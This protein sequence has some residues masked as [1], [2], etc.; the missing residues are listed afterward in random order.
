MARTATDAPVLARAETHQRAHHG[1]W[2]G[3]AG[4]HA[5]SLC[6]SAF[7]V[8]CPRADERQAAPFPGFIEPCLATL[9]SKVPSSRSFVHELKLDGYRVQ[10]HLDNGR[11]AFYARS[12]LDLD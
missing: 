8:T 2:R 6:A 9:W 12:G 4:I 1:S 7:I 10:S 11:V 5:P 3:I